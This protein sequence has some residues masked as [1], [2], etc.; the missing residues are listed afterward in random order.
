MSN[1]PL[2]IPNPST[3]IPLVNLKAQYQTIKAEIDAAIRRIIETSSFILG[4]EL[5]AFEKEFAQYCGVQFAVGTSSGTT[6]IHTA[7]AALRIGLGD[8]VITTPMTFIA[9]TAEI[10]HAGA[11]PVFV[12]IDEQTFTLDVEKVRERIHADYYFDERIGYLVNRLSQRRLKAI[13]PVHLYGQMADMKPLLELARSY[14]LH[15]IEDAAQAHGAEACDEHGAWK[16]AGSFGIA[17]TF[18]FYPGKNLGAYGDAGCVVT[19]DVR[20]ASYMRLFVDQGRTDKYTHAFEGRNYRLD[21]LQAA[22]LRVK[23]PYLD[24]WNARRR[25]IAQQYTRLLSDLPDVTTPTS[26]ALR[27][28][29]FHLYVIQTPRRDELFR[30]LNEQGISAGIHYPKPLHLQPAYEYLGYKQG[31]FPVAEACAQRVLSLPCYPE[32]TDEQIEFIVETIKRLLTG[33]RPSSTNQ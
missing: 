2:N 10:T 32:L 1:Q 8:E 25:A 5:A 29:V 33:H 28:H 19:N 13:M 16:R 18:S 31:D 12:D 6:A 14:N 24:S 26:S 3:T 15:I 23:L 17:A 22:I 20:L 7:L 27:R 30:W 11:R 4:E 9:T 21:T